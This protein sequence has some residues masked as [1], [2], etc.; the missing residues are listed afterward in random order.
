MFGSGSVTPTETKYDNGNKQFRYKTFSQTNSWGS[1]HGIITLQRLARE[2]VEEEKAEEQVEE[3]LRKV[4][5]GKWERWRGMGTGGEEYIVQVWGGG[6]WI[7]VSVGTVRKAD[8]AG[9]R[10]DLDR[11]H[12]L[13]HNLP[14][15]K[16]GPT[17]PPVFKPDWRRWHYLSDPCNL[18][19][20]WILMLFALSHGVS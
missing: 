4:R 14:V 8:A 10:S 1:Q 18:W 12:C 13:P 7:F 9:H 15:H 6:S 11:S 19:R 5:G 3:E 17:T 20:L 16:L 2:V